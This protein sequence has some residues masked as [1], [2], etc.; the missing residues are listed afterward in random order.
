M[1]E[2]DLALYGTG[3]FR[4]HYT[5]TSD[6]A[7]AMLG[8]AYTFGN[9]T[10]IGVSAEPEHQKIVRNSRGRN[11]KVSNPVSSMK[12]TYDLEV[13]QLTFN[14]L[15]R[16]MFVNGQA[17]TAFTRSAG[18][19]SAVDALDFRTSQGKAVDLSRW[20]DLAASGVRALHLTSAALR[21]VNL[22]Y[23]AAGDSTTLLEGKDF[24]LDRTMGAVRFLRTLDDQISATVDF[25]AIAATD[26]LY[27]WIVTPLA[28][29]K[30]TG[31]GVIEVFNDSGN[32]VYKHE[33]F[34][35]DVVPDGDI[36]FNSN[37]STV[38]LKILP[39]LPTGSILA[40]AD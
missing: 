19:G 39:S 30:L 31:I 22:A 3:Q 12:I 29:P 1:L 20:Y 37:L 11:R 25:A 18:S 9:E 4:I 28:N 34:G 38:K 40:N 17:F 15:A 2:S 5:N 26:P 27:S 21:G 16:A 32:L 33:G 14:A 10:K 24:E 7:A 6:A 36:D 35:C 23:G 8:P 13:S